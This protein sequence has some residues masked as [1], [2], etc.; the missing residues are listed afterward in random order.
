MPLNR[1][2]AQHWHL[3]II[4]AEEAWTLLNGGN[5]ID[6]NNGNPNDIRH[7]DP[8][9]VVGVIDSGVQTRGGV[10]E[11]QGLKGNVSDGQAKGR[12][13]VDDGIIAANAPTNVFPSLAW[14]NIDQK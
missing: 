1:H 4:Q 8:S 12:L 5:N 11:H 2:Y 9:I 14:V 3:K 10:I 7:G 13:F 6:L